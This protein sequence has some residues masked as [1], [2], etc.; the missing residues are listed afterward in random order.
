MALPTVTQANFNGVDAGFYIS[1][2]LKE[3]NSLEYMTLMENIK[4]KMN[5][6]QLASSS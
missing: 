1:A 6:Q 3:A 4:Y 2:A 5:I